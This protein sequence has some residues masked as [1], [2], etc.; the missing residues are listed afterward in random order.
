MLESLFEKVASWRLATLLKKTPTQVFSCE[1]CKIFKNTFSYR[2]PLV[3][4][5]ATPVV[6]SEF[7]LKKYYFTAILQPCY[8]V[9]IIFSSPHIIW[10]K[11]VELICLKICCQLSD[12]LNNSLWVYPIK[13]KIDIF[14]HMNNT[15]QNTIF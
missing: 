12:F 15:F 11:K 10:C 4:A 5:S 2:T 1:V 3:T 14:N 13:L 8:D 9:L 6:A 7:F